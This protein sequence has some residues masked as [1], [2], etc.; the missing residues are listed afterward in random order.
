M[1]N[2]GL[3]TVLNYDGEEISAKEFKNKQDIQ[4]NDKTEK[5]REKYI[6]IMEDYNS[7]DEFKKKK[8]I[9]DMIKNLSMYVYSVIAKYFPSY[10]KYKDDL[11]QEGCLAIL[12][13]LDKYNP[14][15]AMP[16]TFFFIYIKEQINTYIIN[17]VNNTSRYYGHNIIK[18]KKAIKHFETNNQ[19]YTNAD[20]AQYTGLSIETVIYTMNAIK[21]ETEIKY[22]TNEFLENQLVSETESPEKILLNNEKSEIILKI[23]ET[24]ND[25]EKFIIMA[26]MGFLGE[27][28]S[29]KEISDKMNTSIDK[30]RKKFQLALIKIKNRSLFKKYFGDSELTEEE[31]MLEGIEVSFVENDLAE[32]IIEELE[33]LQMDLNNII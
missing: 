2:K 27:C 18:I 26:R 5:R 11:Y 9:E 31:R 6:K 15:I 30:I 24:L 13:N 10:I 12:K 21:N 22:D 23:L 17:N 20:I 25:D 16:S 28:L 4:E 3:A 1:N 33:E 14:E 32:G 8:A 29:F 19:D 7:G